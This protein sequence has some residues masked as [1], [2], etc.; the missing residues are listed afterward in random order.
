VKRGTPWRL[1][2]NG[3]LEDVEFRYEQWPNGR[4]IEW[5]NLDNGIG[6]KLGAAPN[7]EW[8]HG[9]FQD[10]L[11][12]ISWNC[13]TG[14]SCGAQ[15]AFESWIQWAL[16][17]DYATT[18]ANDPKTENYFQMARAQSTMPLDNVV[19]S[20]SPDERFLVRSPSTGKVKATG[21]IDSYSAP[22]AEVYWYDITDASSLPV[23]DDEIETEAQTTGSS[24]SGTFTS[25]Y[26]A[27]V[28]PTDCSGD[29]TYTNASAILSLSAVGG[30]EASPQLTFLQTQG[31]DTALASGK[32]VK[33]SLTS[34]DFLANCTSSAC[35]LLG[36]VTPNDTAL[37][38]GSIS[39]AASYWRTGW[40]M[41]LAKLSQTAQMQ[42]S[43]SKEKLSDVNVWGIRGSVTDWD[44]RAL[45]G[46]NKCPYLNL[47]SGITPADAGC[48]PTVI[49]G[50]AGLDNFSG[51][52][53]RQPTTGVAYYRAEPETATT[54]ADCNAAS[55]VGRIVVISGAGVGAGTA[56]LY[57]CTQDSA[58]GI[59]WTRVGG[60]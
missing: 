20:L 10:D 33:Q 44:Q 1:D 28:F 37:V 21:Q 2:A 23:N 13:T 26:I 52:D 5:S 48:T 12:G 42:V 19:G 40:E 4:S 56:G 18:A 47:L 32:C 11:F 39:H 22:N 6:F 50:D 36:T 43:W 60:P 3:N 34:G 29:L 55:E 8:P 35:A 16:E 41:Y 24:G 9:A 51:I 49:V 17:A 38:N 25:G 45:S 27:Y 31:T 46:K 54:S 30:S 58:N 15:S 59:Q 57:V 53:L 14:G 7:R